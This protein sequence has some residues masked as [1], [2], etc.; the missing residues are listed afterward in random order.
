VGGTN[1]GRENAEG[2]ALVGVRLTAQLGRGAK[3]LCCLPKFIGILCIGVL[4]LVCVAF[5]GK[6]VANQRPLVEVW[7]G[8]CNDPN[9]SH[10]ALWWRDLVNV[11]FE[12][13]IEMIGNDEFFGV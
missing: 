10:N 12:P 11:E 13:A 3:A 7:S 8:G 4:E 2:M 9:F 6:N 1:K 5:V